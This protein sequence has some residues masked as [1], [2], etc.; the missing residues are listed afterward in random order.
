MKKGDDA[1]KKGRWYSGNEEMKIEVMLLKQEKVQGRRYRWGVT[2]SKGDVRV[3]VGG[4]VLREEIALSPDKS[5]T[6]PDWVAARNKEPQRDMMKE[7]G[8]KDATEEGEDKIM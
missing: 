1:H 3:V 2:R 4:G 7:E 8:E 6:T 5:L